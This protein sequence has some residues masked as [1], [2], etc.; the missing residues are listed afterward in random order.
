M[1]NGDEC[2]VLPINAL[3]MSEGFKSGLDDAMNNYA[4]QESK[5]HAV[6][7]IQKSVCLS[8]RVAVSLCVAVSVC[9]LLYTSVYVR[10]NG[11]RRTESYSSWCTCMRQ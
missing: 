7:D 1:I 2:C 8:L 9:L 5:R 11:I 4:T 10:A 3:Q 6:D